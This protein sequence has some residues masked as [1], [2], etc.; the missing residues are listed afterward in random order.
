VLSDDSV[1]ASFREVEMELFAADDAL[2]DAVMTRLAAAGAG[3]PESTPKYIRALRALG[4]T[5]PDRTPA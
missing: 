5:I 3:E 2:I 4:R 1:V